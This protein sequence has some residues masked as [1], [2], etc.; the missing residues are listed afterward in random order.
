MK[1]PSGSN[2]VKPAVCDSHIFE[3]GSPIVLLTAQA[4]DAD[5]WV[6]SVAEK[7]NTRLDW[8]YDKDQ[9]G[10][11]LVLHMGDDESR[12][13]AEQAVAQLSPNLKGKILKVYTLRKPRSVVKI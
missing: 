12:K 6:K 2:E 11:A 7:S 4:K 10:A 5:S 8:H 13:R 3:N 9:G 1:K